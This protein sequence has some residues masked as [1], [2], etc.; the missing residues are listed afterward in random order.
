MERLPGIPALRRLAFNVARWLS[1]T[2]CTLELRLFSSET[3][4]TLTPMV[5]AMKLSEHFFCSNTLIVYLCSEVN[6]LYICNTKLINLR[7]GD[8]CS[9]P[10]LHC[11][12]L[13][14]GSSGA[15]RPRPQGKP[16]GVFHGVKHHQDFALLF[17][18]SQ[19]NVFYFFFNVFHGRQE[20]FLAF[21]VVFHGR[22]EVIVKI[23]FVFH[24]RRAFFLHF[25]SSS[26]EDEYSFY[27][28]TALLGTSLDFS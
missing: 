23:S 27:F 24:G 8:E 22:K 25:L 1:Y 5:L 13:P 12:S 19:M 26:M 17:G 7:E 18:K 3:V 15:S 16:R 21:I 6:C 9:P 28:S 10:F 4:L 14:P 2:P 11:L 20:L